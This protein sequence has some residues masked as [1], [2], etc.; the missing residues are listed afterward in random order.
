MK[1][2]AILLQSRDRP[3]DFEKVVNMLKEIKQ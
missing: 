2:I 1:D 3:N